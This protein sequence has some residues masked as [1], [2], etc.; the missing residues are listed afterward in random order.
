M[1][2]ITR[3]LAPL[4]LH[5]ASEA[6]IPVAAA[7]ARAFGAEL[8]LL[9]VCPQERAVGD[10]VSLV[11]AQARTYL[12]TVAAPL[13][14]SGLTA[15]P[16]VRWGAPADTILA[17]IVAQHADLV[18]LGTTVRR[19]LTQWLLGSV[20][21][22][23]VAKATCPVLLVHTPTGEVLQAPVVRSFAEDARRAGAVAPRELGVRTVEISRIVGSV[24][25]APELDAAFRTGKR[26]K[27][28][29]QR[30]KR[31]LKLMEDGTAPPVALYKLGYGYYVLDGNHR[32]AAALQLGQL[33]IEA[34]VTEFVPLGDAQAQRLT[35]E[36]RAFERATGLSRIGAMTPG[37][38]RQLEDMI[39][40][41]AAGQGLDDLH[42]AALRWEATVYRP[43]AD[44]IRRRRS[45]QRFPGERTA[46][47]FVRL[48][49][50]AADIDEATNRPPGQV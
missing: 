26:R 50:S 34:E 19:G 32:V 43:A 38:Y 7:Q 11:E 3:I 41:Y 17:E 1:Q 9:H 2:S 15:R 12:D 27:A 22:E 14:A 13:H 31:V 49:T 35:A 5:S 30:F 48:A 8:I 40:A 18:V 33:E 6:K 21:E 20:A 45:S 10:T 23:V 16:L 39:R 24:G 46:D 47:V 37:H 28:D 29:D 44:K 4:D 36:R 25:R 42:D